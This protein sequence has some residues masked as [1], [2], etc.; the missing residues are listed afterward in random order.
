MFLLSLGKHIIA[1]TNNL[2]QIKSN[3]FEGI[4]VGKSLYVGNID[5]KKAQ[6]ILDTN[7]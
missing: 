5:I 2:K 6:Q 7:A 4:I 1:L 3:N